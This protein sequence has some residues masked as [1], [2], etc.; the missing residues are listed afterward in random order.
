MTIATSSREKSSPPVR[1]T[2]S[3]CHYD[4]FFLHTNFIPVASPSSNGVTMKFNT[5]SLLEPRKIHTVADCLLSLAL[6][7]V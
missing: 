5:L 6:M 2:Q 1:I 7:E 3:Y 4:A